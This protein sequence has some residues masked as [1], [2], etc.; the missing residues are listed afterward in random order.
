MKNDFGCGEKFFHSF[1]QRLSEITKQTIRRKSI[2][3]L[4]ENLVDRYSDGI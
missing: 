3:V 2:K 4:Y 1:V